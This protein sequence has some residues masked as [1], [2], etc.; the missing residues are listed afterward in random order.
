MDMGAAEAANATNLSDS[1]QKINGQLPPWVTLGRHDLLALLH[2]LTVGQAGAWALILAEAL[3]AGTPCLRVDRCREIAG[4]H[5][6]GL[7]ITLSR[8]HKISKVDDDL[9]E[10]RLDF[11]AKSLDEASAKIAKAKRIR[12]GK[13]G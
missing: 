3:S 8:T 1:R 11:V 2:G 13:G 7:W 6:D 10:I 12:A 4:R 9:E 5:W